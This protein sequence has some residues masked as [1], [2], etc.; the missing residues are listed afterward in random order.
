[1]TWR[2]RCSRSSPAT[3]WRSTGSPNN[4][5][6]CSTAYARPWT[7]GWLRGADEIGAY[8][9]APRS[10][11]YALTSAKRIPVERDGS[12]LVARQRDL[13][14]WLHAGGSKRP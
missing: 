11:V 2:V 12:A 8:I 3:R 7:N 5:P 1:M 14:A 9:G 13:D 4:S 6:R 10:R